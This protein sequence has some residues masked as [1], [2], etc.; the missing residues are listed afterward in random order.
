MF[1]LSALI[2][3]W[4]FLIFFLKNSIKLSLVYLLSYFIFIFLKFL[5]V[6]L[7]SYSSEINIWS[8]AY[9]REVGEFRLLDIVASIMWILCEVLVVKYRT[10]GINSRCYHWLS[11]AH[12]FL[13]VQPKLHIVFNS[14]FTK[15]IFN[16]FAVCV[17]CP[18]FL[19]AFLISEI[20]QIFIGIPKILNCP[21]FERHS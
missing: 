10:L 18:N 14:M 9:C 2:L 19:K 11:N 13:T 5:T 17:Y 20:V 4:K 12:F 16:C 7:H 6:I 21:N 15:I 8:R 1:A 3:F